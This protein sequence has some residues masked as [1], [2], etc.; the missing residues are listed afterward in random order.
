M[1]KKAYNKEQSRIAMRILTKG[2]YDNLVWYSFLNENHLQTSQI[3]QRMHKRFK[4]SSIYNVTN[5]LQFYQ[6]G[7]L[8]EKINVK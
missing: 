2:G 5:V 1:S 3:I 6:E 8:I 7:L 4:K